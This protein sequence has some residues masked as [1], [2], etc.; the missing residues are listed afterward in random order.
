MGTTKSGRVDQETWDKLVAAYR[1]DPGNYSAAA[2]I[3]LVQRRTARRA[4]EVGYPDRPWGT[5]S[6]KQLLLEESEL[7]RSRAQ[8]EEDQ[9]QLE[10]ERRAL[11]AERDREAARQHA[12][13]AKQEEAVLVGGA[14]AAAMR[15]LGAAMEAVPGIKAA[16][17][18]ISDDLI[19]K[20]EGG[21]LTPKE[22]A[23]MS[24]TA[25][26]FSSM[27]RDLVQSGQMAMEMERLY[28][29]EPTDVVKVVTELDDLPIADLVRMAGY[30]DQVIQRAA[31][32][33]VISL[34]S[35]TNGHKP[36]SNGAN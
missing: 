31:Q 20:A 29:G 17:K 22:L 27:L 7:A 35:Q 6:I 4:Y 25:R 11:D 9:S 8:L 32:R 15:G 26:R 1:D 30:Q 12:L 3:C 24:A 16:M 34:P 21:P 2:R 18:R 13:R 33:G 19:Q 28:L 5:K 14:R 10:D 23:A 36:G